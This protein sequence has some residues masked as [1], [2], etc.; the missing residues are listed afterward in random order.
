MQTAADITWTTDNLD[1]AT[2]DRIL[3]ARWVQSVIEEVGELGAAAHF[4]TRAAG[5]W[6]ANE[7]ESHAAFRSLVRLIGGA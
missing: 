4:N 2:C 1:R 3:G 6:H 7:R 5:A